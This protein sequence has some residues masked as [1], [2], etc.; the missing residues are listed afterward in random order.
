LESDLITAVGCLE[1]VGDLMTVLPKLTRHVNPGGHL[2][3]IF[4]PLIDGLGAERAAS[5]SADL[6]EPRWHYAWSTAQL[7]QALPG[8]R[9][10]S[11]HLFSAYQRADKPVLYEL[12]LIRRD[13]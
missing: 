13:E 2:A 6:D 8:G 12:L 3:L 11:S 9:L 10:V 1:L 7:L 4:E 5:F